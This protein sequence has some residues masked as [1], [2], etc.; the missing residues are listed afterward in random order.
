MSDKY[1]IFLKVLCHVTQTLFTLSLE[2]N[3]SRNL[4]KIQQNCL[5]NLHWTYKTD[6]LYFHLTKQW[7]EIMFKVVNGGW[8]HEKNNA[9]FI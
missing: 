1:H 4:K 9:T 5:N 2:N 7:N 6:E 8:Q 3:H